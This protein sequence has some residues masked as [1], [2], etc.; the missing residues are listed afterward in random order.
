[1]FA[2]IICFILFLW[3]CTEMLLTLLCLFF[4]TCL[5]YPQLNLSRVCLHNIRYWESDSSQRSACWEHWKHV[6]NKCM[7]WQILWSVL[8]EGP[9]K[10]NNKLNNSQTTSHKWNEVQQCIHEWYIFTS[11]WKNIWFI[12]YFCIQW[13][14]KKVCK[15]LTMIDKK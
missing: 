6:V 13:T 9:L 14:L 11:A 4:C 3:C 7:F 8:W 1:M 5:L 2:L 12:L 15:Y 10:N